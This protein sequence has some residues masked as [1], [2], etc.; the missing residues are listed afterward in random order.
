[1]R[2]GK[3]KSFAKCYVCAVRH[4]VV[5]TNNRENI[6]MRV[7]TGRQ[8]VMESPKCEVPHKREIC[9]VLGRFV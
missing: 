9:A 6:L 2:R 7:V 8:L 3:T 1:M 5:V 4:G